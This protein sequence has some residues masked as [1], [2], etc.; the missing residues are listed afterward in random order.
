[1]G[2]CQEIDGMC[3]TRRVMVLTFCIYILMMAA[4]ALEPI[5]AKHMLP[6][7]IRT[8]PYSPLLMVAGENKPVIDGIDGRVADLSL[9]AGAAQVAHSNRRVL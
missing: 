7:G 3:S 1:M 2:T 9:F 8:L 5:A 6:I 4:T